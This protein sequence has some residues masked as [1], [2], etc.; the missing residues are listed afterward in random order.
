MTLF[1]TGRFRKDGVELLQAAAGLADD[2]AVRDGAALHPLHRAQQQQD[3]RTNRL[4]PRL[5]SGIDFMKLVR[6][7]K[8]FESNF[9]AFNFGQIFIP[10]QQANMHLIILD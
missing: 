6:R 9:L 1:T 4:G 3:A 5:A 8:V 7:R 2:D 10:K